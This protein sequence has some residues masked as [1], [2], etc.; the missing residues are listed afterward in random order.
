MDHI[1][2]QAEQEPCATNESNHSKW[3]R[4]KPV[5]T[6]NNLRDLFLQLSRRKPTECNGRFAGAVPGAGTFVHPT[7]PLHNDKVRGLV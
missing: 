2:G 3:D 7:A 5:L 6:F 1:S 4:A